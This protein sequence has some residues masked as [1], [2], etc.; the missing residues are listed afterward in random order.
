MHKA[1]MEKGHPQD[2]QMKRSEG[3]GFFILLNKYS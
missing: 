2:L 3:C 1:V